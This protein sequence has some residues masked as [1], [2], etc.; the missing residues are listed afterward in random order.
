MERTFKNERDAK[1][2]RRDYLNETGAEVSLIA[3]D[4]ARE[5]FVFDVYAA[6]PGDEYDD[7]D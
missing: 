4:T 2:S 3:F 6:A 1:E 5:V 7:E